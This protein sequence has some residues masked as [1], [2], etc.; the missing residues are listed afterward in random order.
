M[1]TVIILII[2]LT[3][4]SNSGKHDRPPIKGNLCNV[5]SSV[6]S[7]KQKQKNLCINN[8][9]QNCLPISARY[10]NV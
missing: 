6:S 5:I 3:E 7:A 8:E 4:G 1:T 9:M 10:E 2:I